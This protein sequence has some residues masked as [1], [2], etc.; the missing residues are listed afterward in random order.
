MIAEA[1]VNHDGSLEKALALVDIA[2]A[3]GAD[4]VKFQTFQPELLASPDAEKAG[5]Q[6]ETTGSAESQLA[7]LTRLALSFEAFTE[8]KRYCDRRRI[9]F[10]STPFDYESADFLDSI[11]MIG[12][13]IPSGEL[14]NLPFLAHIGSK[15]KPAILSTGMGSL[16]EVR[17]AV[18]TL[19][20]SGC[21]AMA[22]LQ[23]VSNYPA[24]AC[25]ANLRAMRTLAELGHTVGYS[26]HTLGL[27]IAFASVA[28]G[29]TVLE[30]HFTL[31]RNASGPDHRCSLEPGQLAALVDGVRNIEFSLG[32]GRKEAAAAEQVTAL[33]A[34]RSLFVRQPLAAGETIMA[35][36]LE[37][38][39]PG[40]GISPSR[41]YDV[42]GR[43]ARYALAARHKLTPEDLV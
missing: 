22:V 33:V 25:D 16:A 31:D 14:V 2:V 35:E 43:R 38:L 3:A 1:G 32:N 9:I 37:A 7:M 17:D 27:E 18:V 39:R 20:R 19:E 12:F 4:A 30:K 13:K 15:R 5:Y 36:H 26:D 34:R 29:A 6:K 41:F 28:L 11:E 24:A 23:C 10:L 8:I 42:V 21:P 40:D